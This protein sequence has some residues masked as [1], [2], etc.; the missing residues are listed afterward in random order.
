MLSL[1]LSL[2][3]PLNKRSKSMVLKRIPSI[4]SN[5]WLLSVFDSV[6]CRSIDGVGVGAFQIIFMLT[7]CLL[8]RGE[9]GKLVQDSS[10]SDRKKEWQA[11]VVYLSINLLLNFRPFLLVFIGEFCFVRR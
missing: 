8:L 4:Q 11:T 10:G 5:G 6:R 3:T 7:L 9:N 1:F 2:T